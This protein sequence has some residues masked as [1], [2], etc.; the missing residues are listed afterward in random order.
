MVNYLTAAIS[1]GYLLL[2]LYLSYRGKR[3]FGAFRLLPLILVLGFLRYGVQIFL[4]DFSSQPLINGIL[5]IT[6]AMFVA[7]FGLLYLHLVQYKAVGRL[8]LYFALLVYLPILVLGLVILINVPSNINQ[9]EYLIRVL[10]FFF[11][12]VALY[13]SLVESPYLVN[14]TIRIF[15][16]LA[17]ISYFFLMTIE[18]SFILELYKSTTLD[19]LNT[20]F[21]FI[22]VISTFAIILLNINQIA[23]PMTSSE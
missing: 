1:A 3:Q 20:A 2:L 8:K 10:L 21:G 14:G 13:F 12:T 18:I 11:A 23:S 16:Y 4:F 19:T 17:L 6:D 7:I 22:D 15:A 5:I 9:L